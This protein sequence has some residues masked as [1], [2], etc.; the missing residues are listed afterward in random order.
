MRDAIPDLEDVRFNDTTHSIRVRSGLREA[1]EE[2]D[3]RGACVLLGAGEYPSLDGHANR[4]TSLREV[5]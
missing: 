1:C 4:I 3:F 2:A 5:R